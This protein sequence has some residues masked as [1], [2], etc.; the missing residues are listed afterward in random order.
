MAR[1]HDLSRPLSAARAGCR[2]ERPGIRPGRYGGRDAADLPEMLEAHYGVPMCGAILNALNTR[3]DAATLAFILEHG[4][5][6]C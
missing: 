5:A 6:R 1:A 2:L 4:E 3:L